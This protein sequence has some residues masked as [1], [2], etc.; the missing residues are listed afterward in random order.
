MPVASSGPYVVAVPII[1]IIG[2]GG[3]VVVA[4][5]VD[6]DSHCSCGGGCRHDVEVDHFHVCG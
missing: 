5:A 2:G 6:L 4:V 3:G 1:T